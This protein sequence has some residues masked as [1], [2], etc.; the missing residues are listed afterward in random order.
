M[1]PQSWQREKVNRLKL[2]M[3]L[4]G[5][6]YEVKIISI[7]NLHV[8][9]NLTHLQLQ[10]AEFGQKGQFFFVFG[11]MVF[12]FYHL[13]GHHIRFHLVRITFSSD[14]YCDL[15]H[16]SKV[17]LFRTLTHYVHRN[18]T[19]DSIKACHDFV[20]IHLRGCRKKRSQ[21]KRLPPP[22]KTPGGALREGPSS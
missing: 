8:M 12:S 5:H 2:K 18:G 14:S 20:M 17:Y 21:T 3:F 19:F 10:T 7:N 16:I 4:I 1:V 6:I 22:L 13:L 11:L 9:P 15:Q